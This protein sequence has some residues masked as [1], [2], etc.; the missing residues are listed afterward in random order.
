M[1]PSM[2][3]A[4]PGEPS[5]SRPGTRLLGWAADV[6]LGGASG[7]LVASMAMFGIQRLGWGLWSVLPP[8]GVFVGMALM[9]WDRDRA[10]HP[11]R[12]RTWVVAA[13]SIMTIG[14]VVLF[15]GLA[16]AISNFE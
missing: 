14:A 5:S 16:M 7:L 10:P 9:R 4:D 12:H 11:G 8:L 13:A 1:M 2:T 3:N 6:A 15:V